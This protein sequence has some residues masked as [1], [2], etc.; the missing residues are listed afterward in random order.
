[1]PTQ[2]ILNTNILIE[3]YRQYRSPT[4]LQASGFGIPE[5]QSDSKLIFSY[6]YLKD[7]D[8]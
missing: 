4:L 5:S 1:M 6:L 7:E 2:N 8:Y 3:I